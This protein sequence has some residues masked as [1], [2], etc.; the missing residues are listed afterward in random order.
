M[1]WVAVLLPMRSYMI[2]QFTT[3]LYFFVYLLPKFTCST[4]VCKR[5]IEKYE[6]ARWNCFPDASVT[7][8]SRMT[9]KR[10]QPAV[11][12][13]DVRNWCDAKLVDRPSLS[14]TRVAESI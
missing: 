6:S 8:S 9:A 3:D 2:T 11:S 1:Y 4:L 13:L 12:I 10:K 14:R 5:H 7:V